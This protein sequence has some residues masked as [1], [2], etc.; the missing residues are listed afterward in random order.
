[1]CYKSILLYILF[2][3]TFIHL[4]FLYEELWEKIFSAQCNRILLLLALIGGMNLVLYEYFKTV[5]QKPFPSILLSFCP[6]LATSTFHCFSSKPSR[7]YGNY[8]S[9]LSYTTFQNNREKTFQAI[10]PDG[11]KKWV[12]NRPNFLSFCRWPFKQKA[13]FCISALGRFK[14]LQMQSVNMVDTMNIFSISFGSTGVWRKLKKA[15]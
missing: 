4:F 13:Y 1:M 14:S 8:S 7:V 9:F 10:V 12:R 2:Y 11:I 6:A 15:G 3:S 5:L